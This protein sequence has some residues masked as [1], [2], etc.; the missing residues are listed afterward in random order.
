MYN[1]SVGAD[2]K[3]SGPRQPSSD[4][5]G[6]GHEEATTE[7]AKAMSRNQFPWSV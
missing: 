3:G 4:R 1:S 6:R 7:D 5:N 2:S